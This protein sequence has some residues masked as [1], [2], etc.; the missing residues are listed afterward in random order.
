MKKQYRHEIADVAVGDEGEIACDCDS[1]QAP[2]RA[3]P[4]RGENETRGKIA[5]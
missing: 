3:R 1:A 5:D 2:H 4:E